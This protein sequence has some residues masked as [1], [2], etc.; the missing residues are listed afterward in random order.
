MSATPCPSTAFCKRLEAF[1]EAIDPYWD[2][3]AAC[4]GVDLR[5]PQRW[6]EGIKP[7]WDGVNA[8][9]K[10]AARS[11]GGMYALFGVCVL[12]PVGDYQPPLSVDFAPVRGRRRG[13]GRRSAAARTRMTSL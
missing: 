13:V 12:P 3:L 6:R 7:S 9:V 4:L 5:Q 2:I 1:M 10:L 8:L 11:P